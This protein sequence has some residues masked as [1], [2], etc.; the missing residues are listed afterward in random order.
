MAIFDGK[1]LKGLVGKLV[2]RK[3]GKK[4]I[5]Q[6]RPIQ[7]KQTQATKESAKLFGKA[8]RLAKNIRDGLVTALNADTDGE[9]V[10][11]FNTEVRA[12]LQ[13]CLNPETNK[14]EFKADSFS[15]LTD[16]EFNKH[17][18]FKNYFWESVQTEIS[19]HKM[20][21]HIPTFEVASQLKF[22]DFNTICE[23]NAQVVMLYLKGKGLSKRLPLQTLEIISTQKISPAHEFSFEVPDGCLCVV[24]LY[25]KYYKMNKTSKMEYI[26]NG[27]YPSKICGAWISPG[28]PIV[29]EAMEKWNCMELELPQS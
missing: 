4:Q 1:H 8:S 13:H 25:L 23:L 3:H 5:V 21:I 16:F 27:F 6:G 18:P 14:F 12:I 19:D 20:H 15:R 29:T 26:K 28:I 17:S 24:G 22:P 7:V 11:R 2:L 10:N 9:M